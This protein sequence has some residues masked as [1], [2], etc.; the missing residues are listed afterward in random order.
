LNFQNFNE[1][2]FGLL[3]AFRATDR[4]KSGAAK[5]AQKTGV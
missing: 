2:V 1:Q 4:R 5:A 3:Q